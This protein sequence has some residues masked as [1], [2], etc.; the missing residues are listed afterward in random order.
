[1]DSEVLVI[2]KRSDFVRVSQRGFRV[3][4]SSLLVLCLQKQRECEILSS[5]VGYTASRKVG[6]AVLRN[7]AKRRLRHLVLE[8]RRIISGC[9]CEF[10]FIANSKTPHIDFS[11]LKSEFL[12]CIL[13]CKERLDSGLNS[14]SCF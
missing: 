8:F 9:G 2:K 6:S 7:R 12:S 11:I 3:K 4:A 5:N 1:M 13:R 14:K 10:V